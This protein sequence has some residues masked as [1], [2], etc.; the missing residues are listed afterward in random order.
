M[1]DE[2]RQRQSE[3]AQS[4]KPW[5]NSTGPKSL[6]GKAKVAQNALKHGLRGGVF[7]QAHNLLSKNNQLLKGLL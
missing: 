7:R 3:I 1:N 4:T 6:E 5:K 2:R